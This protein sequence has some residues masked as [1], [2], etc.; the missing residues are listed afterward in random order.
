M[1]SEP[2]RG[3]LWGMRRTAKN[4]PILSPT[5][6]QKKLKLLLKRMSQRELSEETDV[7]QPAI[8]QLA[9]GIRTNPWQSTKRKFEKVGIEIDDWDR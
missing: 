2:R 8:C 7:A 5:A 3:K 9:S 4:R 6:A 1:P